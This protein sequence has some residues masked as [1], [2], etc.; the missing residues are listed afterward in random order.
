VH[1]G[2]PLP[3]LPNQFQTIIEHNYRSFDFNNNYTEEYEEFYDFVNDR[4]AIHKRSN[5]KLIQQ[6]FLY[7]TNEMITVIGSFPLKS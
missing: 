7:T 4:A 2:I 3:D 6:Y 1:E 5:L